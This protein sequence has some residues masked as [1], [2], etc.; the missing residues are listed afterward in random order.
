[1]GITFDV[2]WNLYHKLFD[3]VQFTSYIDLCAYKCG[4]VG[5]KE[6]MLP[7]LTSVIN[8]EHLEIAW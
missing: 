5:G 1:M 4:R 3:V 8:I 7:F 2:Q 6:C